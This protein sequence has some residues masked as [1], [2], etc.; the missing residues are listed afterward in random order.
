MA[1]KGNVDAQVRVKIKIDDKQAAVLQH[2]TGESKK[3]GKKGRA[4]DE[5]IKLMFSG[6]AKE[7][8]TMI[9]SVFN[10][11]T[12]IELQAIKS[13]AAV[14]T[15]NVE[16]NKV[17][18]T[19]NA[20]ASGGLQPRNRSQRRAYGGPLRTMRGEERAIQAQEAMNRNLAQLHKKLSADKAGGG[21]GTISDREFAQQVGALPRDI[22]KALSSKT[23]KGYGSSGDY[24]PPAARTPS[25]GFSK[26]AKAISAM[27]GNITVADVEKIL[28]ATTAAARGT[29]ESAG[30]KH[31]K[32]LKGKKKARGYQSTP[33]TEQLF[34]DV[35]A[36]GKTKF[37][38]NARILANRRLQAGGRSR[39]DAPGLDATRARIEQTKDAALSRAEAK[40]AKEVAAIDRTDKKRADREEDAANKRFSKDRE[41]IESRADVAKRAAE[42]K[43]ITSTGDT[44]RPYS[45]SDEI[46]SG[47]P[48]SARAWDMMHAG[49][50]PSTG[51]ISDKLLQDPSSI[52]ARAKRKKA[53]KEVAEDRAEQDARKAGLRPVAQEKLASEK[54]ISAAEQ[55]KI[56]AA[57]AKKFRAER[58]ARDA[59]IK[60][61]ADLIRRDPAAP[62]GVFTPTQIPGQPAEP[63][64]PL[65]YADRVAARR[66]AREATADLPERPDPRIANKKAGLEKAAATRAAKKER[67]AIINQR[68]EDAADDSYISQTSTKKEADSILSRRRKAIETEARS[69]NHALRKETAAAKR[70]GTALPSPTATIKEEIA[71]REA[72][73]GFATT[74]PGLA[75][76]SAL[77][78]ERDEKQLK[79]EKKAAAAQS[80]AEKRRAAQNRQKL[81]RRKH[82]S[83]LKS[84][85]GFLDFGASTGG[86]SMFESVARFFG[87]RPP[88][89][90]PSHRTLSPTE[91]KRVI[92]GTRDP[93]TGALSDD[94]RDRPTY[95]RREEAA[96]AAK[97][98]KRRHQQRQ[99]R[100]DAG[101][102]KA[103][104]AAMKAKRASTKVKT[105]TAKGA[106]TEI[107][108]RAQA[109]ADA[110]KVEA[111]WTAKRAKSL[112]ALAK[113]GKMGADAAVASTKAAA[114]QTKATAATRAITEK[115]PGRLKSEAGFIDPGRARDVLGRARARLSEIAQPAIAAGS[116]LVEDVKARKQAK[117]A[118]KEETKKFMGGKE[119]RSQFAPGDPTKSRGFGTAV[120]TIAQYAGASTIIY[121]VSSA[122][123]DA[124]S[125]ALKFEDALT[126]VQGVL[127]TR[128]FAERVQLKGEVINIARQY[129]VD[130]LQVAE[131]AKIFAQ[132]GL[133]ASKV[134]EELGAT[135]LAV[136]GIGLQ[137]QQAREMLTA[138]RNITEEQMSSYEVLDRISKIEQS[139]AVDASS[140]ADALKQAGPMA[141]QLAGNFQ[142]S[143]TALDVVL[144]TTTQIVEQ[145]RVSGRQAATS[146][147]FIL[148]R[149]GRPQVLKQLE[150]IGQ[151]KL[152]TK[153]SGGKQLRP[154]VE[155]MHELADAYE[156]IKETRG[157]ASAT[158]FLVA[159]A[160]A[161][162]INPAAVILGSVSEAMETARLGAYAYGDAQ[163]RLNLQQ[164]T[165]VATSQRL[166]TEMRTFGVEMLETS[167]YGILLK[168]TMDGLTNVFQV[169]GD[170]ATL[171]LVTVLG[172]V[173]GLTKGFAAL[174]GAMKS[175]VAL[176]IGLQ[177]T[178]ALG[179]GA[180]EA[181]LIAK[182]AEGFGYVGMS[183]AE[184]ERRYG[185]KAAR[186]A[187][188]GKVRGAG[189]LGVGLASS[190]AW[191]GGTIIPIVIA[192][193]AAIA[194]AAFIAKTVS[195]AG[196]GGPLAIDYLKQGDLDPSQMPRLTAFRETADA[197]GIGV[198][199]LMAAVEHASAATG[200]AARA[201][202]R[203]TDLEAAARKQFNRAV[204]ED[205]DF[206]TD[207]FYDTQQA[208]EASKRSRTRLR[209]HDLGITSGAD[210]TTLATQ[211]YE[212][213]RALTS[214]R[215]EAIQDRRDLPLV[216][217]ITALQASGTT[218]TTGLASFVT[219]MGEILDDDAL[220]RFTAH[221]AEGTDGLSDLEAE[222]VKAERALTM[223]AQGAYVSSSISANALE[224]TRDAYRN[225]G[226][227]IRDAAM[228]ADQGDLFKSKWFRA[229]FAPDAQAIAY[230]AAVGP[231][232]R[233]D[234]SGGQYIRARTLIRE[235]FPG[236][237]GIPDL[238]AET[239]LGSSDVLTQAALKKSPNW[240]EYFKNVSDEYL[241][242][243][244][245]P[246]RRAA[247]VSATADAFG[248]ALETKNAGLLDIGISAD[249]P[250]AGYLEAMNTILPESFKEL[251]TRLIAELTGGDVTVG[252]AK[253]LEAAIAI[254][255]EGTAVDMGTL[256]QALTQI[257]NPL[258][259]FI[260]DF[261]VA[262]QRLVNTAT[263]ADALG[264]S[265]NLA[266]S[267]LKNFET[268]GTK[269][270]SLKLDTT[271]R[272]LSDV[273][274]LE[275]TAG[276][277]GGLGNLQ[278][279][280]ALG[281]EGLG[282]AL[283][284]G[285]NEDVLTQSASGMKRIQGMR[286][287]IQALNNILGSFESRDM[288]ASF[289]VSKHPEAA[290][291]INE[292]RGFYDDLARAADEISGSD[293]FEGQA[294]NLATLVLDFPKLMRLWPIL[295]Q[296][297]RDEVLENE[298]LV[299]TYKRAATAANAAAQ[300]EKNRWGTRISSQLEQHTKYITQV[301][302]LAPTLTS[303][304]QT[305]T[306][307]LDL[308]NAIYNT[309]LNRIENMRGAV[310]YTEMMAIQAERTA[311]T[312]LISA[313]QAATLRREEAAFAARQ[314]ETA[315]QILEIE[316]ARIRTITS[317]I[318]TQITMRQRLVAMEKTITD[319]QLQSSEALQNQY[320]PTALKLEAVMERIAGTRTAE[321]RVAQRTYALE[322]SR[323]RQME[324]FTP[325]YEEDTARKEREAAN[326]KLQVDLQ[327]AMVKS[328]EAS[329]VAEI[330]SREQQISEIVSARVNNTTARLAGLKE[331]LSNYET[332]SNSPERI[333]EA[334]GKAFL[335]RQVDLL[336]EGLFNSK[337]GLLKGLGEALGAVGERYKPITNAHVEG[338]M[339]GA[340]LLRQAI[341]DGAQTAGAATKYS[342]SKSDTKSGLVGAKEDGRP[343]IFQLRT[344][345]EKVSAPETL[346]AVAGA[347]TAA[348]IA[349]RDT[350]PEAIT[351]HLGALM[352][353]RPV[354]TTMAMQRGSALG[355]G[356]LLR[357]EV[358]DL[359][360]Q[361]AAS[362]H[363]PGGA[364]AIA[365]IVN[366][367][368][369]E[370]QADF[371]RGSRHQATAPQTTTRRSATYNPRV[372]RIAG[373]ALSPDA[374]LE[375]N[376]TAALRPWE[377][378]TP[379]AQSSGMTPEERK[380]VFKKQQL[381]QIAQ[382]A[383]T[384][385]GTVGGSALGG[386]NQGAQIGSQIGS[387]AGTAIGT[388][389]GGPIG[390]AIGSAL[391]GLAGGLFGGIFGGDDKPFQALEA[392]KRSSAE[393][394][395]LLENT[396]ALLNPNNVSF[397]MPTNFA[398]PGYSPTGYGSGLITGDITVNFTAPVDDPIAVGREIA[399]SLTA[400]LSNQ[401]NTSGVYVSRG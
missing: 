141:T 199:Q 159:L 270:H 108:S 281:S 132:Q 11:L 15:V 56:D 128:S 344:A 85:G 98:E 400:E 38:R 207:P 42:R 150:Q 65:S 236:A 271:A 133:S 291:S 322:L 397:N 156:R 5:K 165:F 161:R 310:G 9:D 40:H 145:T 389:L 264:F 387:M 303:I 168:G 34:D 31:F 379:S 335:S 212:D 117:A 76:E 337:A 326:N 97:K 19:P 176:Q 196:K 285:L 93:L 105:Q 377:L 313:R 118:G 296:A 178:K 295:T 130:L 137:T 139:R 8:N 269:L 224:K 268:Y 172:A 297:K 385:V 187:S 51:P 284:A 80:K 234:R 258:D 123:R 246:T 89:P 25:S 181:A 228:A 134:V 294:E 115:I 328:N 227:S 201:G 101:E 87:K 316:G 364:D 69:L 302:R 238:V 286:T 256:A 166:K 257:K 340:V 368:P 152:G 336:F 177:A 223:L 329:I 100:A 46:I 53:Y 259:E 375:Q 383:G 300:S 305:K 73:A 66:K 83:R 356:S 72:K 52:R 211:A 312:M 79:A 232:R 169:F 260:R 358:L 120:R 21:T 113:D 325:D 119:T 222:A 311:K 191:S 241:K 261:F 380:A 221:L 22:G 321:Q 116:R 205:G 275:N 266:A 237:E 233:D 381:E 96:E 94:D 253:E 301:E 16:Q 242:A 57:E 216:D 361:R 249:N 217:N 243:V 304:N 30:D 153:E 366:S 330:Q 357:Q 376:W 390:G 109:A 17:I 218:R 107:I 289:D 401:V 121:G 398:L 104:A 86:P 274:K 360:R 248:N 347:A 29:L 306:V 173:L 142:G 251:E 349:V 81:A 77:E 240:T 323:I 230:G 373:A 352:N 354:Q 203:D 74:K 67:Q 345:I 195:D 198:T 334:A 99:R 272:V 372:R 355:T 122:F 226:A 162:Q 359:E 194:T 62:G 185:K 157:S 126:R 298:R 348:T 363:F 341:I 353:E 171:K 95:K 37:Q 144:G 317:G 307:E 84:Q 149:L 262:E 292:L 288:L 175:V 151:V 220:P 277:V 154:L 265:F 290:R 129:S 382:S 131:S 200:D 3:G 170:H 110:A 44:R 23:L 314:A 225:L 339:Q 192:A 148:A 49:V 287:E 43:R 91:A 247:I 273:L 282:S 24:L 27:T 54:K 143:V 369:P 189:R 60:E 26:Q 320:M 338:A 158:R 252:R 106:S 299:I 32:D 102:A 1:K 204:R 4:A 138:V 182:R 63:S 39:T 209:L 13:A 2:L 146:M 244:Q 388:S 18:K 183:A 309:E 114:K 47:R 318:T 59:R 70:A 213:A 50:V 235:S 184:G 393:Q 90:V 399:S 283:Y 308:A 254:L 342:F 36:P 155:I 164:T 103:E 136:Q 68:A 365:N 206:R 384:L 202:L 210:R 160:G 276:L 140:L 111:D 208:E 279:M 75:V 88:D 45:T 179:A 229:D 12:K 186:L 64:V 167:G 35:L 394:V 135:M 362:T 250:F 324:L 193:V 396:N 367:L 82:V 374:R 33:E 370:Q 245:D 41:R 315:R 125:S 10:G 214:A 346:A 219:S 174:H 327:S 267:S 378:D 6:D 343:P 190:A 124:F 392:I 28:S 231:N 61:N 58:R 215:S 7:V 197:I 48:I 55:K 391:G 14:K 255:G 20:S 293:S 263:A 371:V 386:G 331:V 188:R 147:R 92:S 333:F 127:P 319:A 332:L 280:E 180:T 112:R 278:Q 395:K 351:A 163:E 78:T 239:L 350:S 71:R